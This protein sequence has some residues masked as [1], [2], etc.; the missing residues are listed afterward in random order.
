MLTPCTRA[1]VTAWL[2]R[3]A[4]LAWMPLVLLAVSCETLAPVLQ[5][6]LSQ[7]EVHFRA[8]RGSTTTLSQTIAVQNGGDGRLGPVSCPA[9]PAAWL[10]CDVTGGNSVKFTANPTGL[11]T[12]PAVAAVQLTAPGVPNAPAT[13]TVDLIIEQPVLTVSAG[14]V[15][16][17]ATE[18]S[19]TTTPATATVTVTNTGAGA[20]ADLGPLSCAAAPADARVVCTVDPATGALAIRVDPAGLTPGTYVFPV[21]VSA[22]NNS[23]TQTVTVSLVVSG[24][25]RIVLSQRAVSFSAIRGGLALQTQTVTVSNSGSGSLGTVSCPSAPATWLTCSVSGSAVTLSGNPAGLTA[26]P[27]AVTVNVSASGAVNSPQQI[28]AS[29]AIEQPV[30]SVSQSAVSFT[31]TEGST[32]TTPTSAPVTVTNTGAGNLAN[33]GTITCSVVTAGAPLACSVIQVSGTVQLSVDPS[34]LTAGTHVFLAQVAAPHSSVN[35]VITV[36]V[37]V[38]AQPRLVLSPQVLVFTAIRGS[39]TL[40][41]Q[42]VTASNGGG[43]M[44]GALDCPPNPAPWLSCTP[45][46]TVVTFVANPSGLTVSPTPVAV[47]VDAAGAANTPQT[48]TVNLII[49]QPVLT[50]S[51]SNV[52]FTVTAPSTTAQVANVTVTNSGTGGLAALGAIACAKSPAAAP[53]TCVVNP[54][55]GVATIT[56]DP[57][58]LTPEVYVYT[59][60]VSAPNMSNAPQTVTIVLRVN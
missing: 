4:R 52:S 6:I 53:V 5:L 26:S 58:G 17:T 44:L 43:G 32:T 28:T 8:L 48:V 25:P 19:A 30:L 9:A 60:T 3:L 2:T 16:L 10:T 51:A 22:P 21:Q 24:L 14:S 40:M 12:S 27:T 15:S 35:R 56:V 33:L 46:T 57:T 50:L 54:I 55:S 42:N 41:A 7:P 29:F 34:S 20:L 39:T 59:V 11:T 23:T 31:A 38:G 47:N 49:E 13:V 36:T 37:V 1:V 45:G 18:G